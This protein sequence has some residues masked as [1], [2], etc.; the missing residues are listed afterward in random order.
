MVKLKKDFPKMTRL[1]E[2]E[3]L[4][5]VIGL[6]TYFLWLDDLAKEEGVNPKELEYCA[7]EQMND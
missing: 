3:L 4:L 5:G 1:E 2:K 7:C 6:A